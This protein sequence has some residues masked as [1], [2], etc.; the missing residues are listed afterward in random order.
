MKLRYDRWMLPLTVPF[1]LGPKT[2]TVAISGADLHVRMGWE[3]DATIPLAS[4]TSATPIGRRVFGW[5]V[6]RAAG[7]GWLVNGSSRGLVD[8]VI[9][10]PVSAQAVRMS[11]KL[12][13]LTI[14]VDD[15]DEL[16]AAC[17]RAT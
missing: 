2:S 5:G 13:K 17:P 3:F 6:H 1:G 9:D 16:I 7:G 8:L 12:S 4:I 11:I 10:P 14:S 15:P